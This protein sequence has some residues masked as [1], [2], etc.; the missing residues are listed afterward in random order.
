MGE[1]KKYIVAEEYN[2]DFDYSEGDVLSLSPCASYQFDNTGIKYSVLSDYLREE[3]VRKDEKEIFDKEMAWCGNFDEYLQSR[4]TVFREKNIL[5]VYFHF[6]RFKYLIDSLVMQSRRIKSFLKVCMPAEVVYIGDSLLPVEDYSIFN[7][8]KASRQMFI[9]LFEVVCGEYGIKFS[10]IPHKAAEPENIRPAEIIEKSRKVLKHFYGKE[11]NNI[12]KYVLPGRFMPGR[13]ILKGKKILSLDAGTLSID[14]VIIELIKRG[15]DVY[16]KNGSKIR[17]ICIFPGKRCFLADKKEKGPELA[18]KLRETASF[19]AEAHKIVRF[20]SDL[21]EVN[22]EELFRPFLAWFVENDC[23][24][25][26]YEYLAMEKFYAENNIDSVIA[27]SSSGINYP[28]ALNASMNSKN[29]KR[30]CF[31][32]SCGPL[33]WRDLYQGDIGY[34]DYFFST[35][36]A[37]EEIYKYASKKYNYGSCKIYQSPHYLQA[38]EKKYNHARRK[39]ERPLVI[40]VPK[41]QDVRLQKYNAGSVLLTWYYDFLKRIINYMANRD[42][43]HFIF[44]YPVSSG[45]YHGSIIKYI[46]SLK[47]GNISLSSEKMYKYFAKAE[48]LIQDNAST[49]M[50][51]ACAAG[52][53]VLAMYR[54]PLTPSAIAEKEFSDILKPYND[55]EDAISH[56]EGFLD[57]PPEKYMKK[58]GFRNDD[59]SV[60]F[61]GV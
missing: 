5:P 59:L 48:R 1:R 60:I 26:F 61:E 42:D 12:F 34:F 58:I 21:C 29:V 53:S 2:P 55:S 3:E 24:K 8:R 13:K 32:H 38:I 10:F 37:S 57:T 43:F 47:P 27:R 20:I 52:L 17:E 23:S 31:Q 44:K 22:T 25:F 11:V 40:F 50:F 41:K 9:K 51:E 35:D 39:R 49:P 56:I 14:G 54:K 33:D 16:I 28:A 7:I 36:S 45:W 19:P 6:S 30:V 4:L 15:A 18:G 46:N